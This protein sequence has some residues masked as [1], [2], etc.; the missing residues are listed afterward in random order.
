LNNNF[1]NELA[2]NTFTPGGKIN[3]KNNTQVQPGTSNG[4]QGGQP[5]IVASENIGGVGV[6]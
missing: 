4:V 5:H 2:S 3:S 1:Q 6:T